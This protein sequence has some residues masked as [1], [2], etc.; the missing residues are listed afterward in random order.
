MSSDLPANY[1]RFSALLL[2]HFENKFFSLYHPINFLLLRHALLQRWR[3]LQGVLDNGLLDLFCRRLLCCSFLAARGLHGTLA[4]VLTGVWQILH[5]LLA[6]SFH[7][8]LLTLEIPLAEL[9]LGVFRV[10]VVEDVDDGVD[11]VHIISELSRLFLSA[12]GN[13]ACDLRIGLMNAHESS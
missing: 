12:V 7:G 11:I 2:V 3:L 4:R 1:H 6:R 9:F 5:D 8:F 10:L 13:V